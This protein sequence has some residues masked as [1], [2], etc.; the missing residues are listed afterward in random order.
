MI[1]KFIPYIVA[2]N[3]GIMIIIVKDVIFFTIWL[4]L[5]DTDERYKSRVPVRISL[6]V[7]TMSMSWITS[8]YRLRNCLTCFFS[9]SARYSFSIEVITSLFAESDL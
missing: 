2:M 7:L 5:L 8:L 6:Y 4:R 3:V 9:M 1:L